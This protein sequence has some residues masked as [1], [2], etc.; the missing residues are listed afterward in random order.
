MA[1]LDRMTF[2]RMYEAHVLLDWREA[3]A[4]Y[5]QAQADAAGRR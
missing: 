5:E 3:V 2:R 4:E 1:D